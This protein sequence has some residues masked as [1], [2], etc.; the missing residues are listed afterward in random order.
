MSKEL[1]ALDFVY[2]DDFLYLD[3]LAPSSTILLLNSLFL[4]TCLCQFGISVS[5]YR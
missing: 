1:I 2:I 5:L 4:A 3:V